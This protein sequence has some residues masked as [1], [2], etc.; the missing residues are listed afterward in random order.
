MLLKNELILY[1]EWS[2][3]SCPSSLITAVVRGT[4]GVV[5]ALS[6][7]KNPLILDIHLV[8]TRPQGVIILLWGFLGHTSPVFCF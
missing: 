6:K 3:L 8:S 5:E 2:E 7:L 4:T 1:C